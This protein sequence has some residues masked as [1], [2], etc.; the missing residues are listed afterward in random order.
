MGLFAKNPNEVEY[1]GGKKHWTDVIKNS[2][3][4][5]LLIWRQPEEDF[6]TNSTLIVM[7]GEQAIFIK[8]GTIEQVF[9]TSGT[10]KLSTENYPF[11]SRLRNAFSGGISTFN[12]VVYFVR[13]AHSM[14]IKWGTMKKFGVRDKVYGIETNIGAFGSYKVSVS[15]P[16]LFL[17]KLIGNNIV[18]ETQDGLDDYFAD[19]FQSKIV[20]TLS[21][22]IQ[23]FPGEI[24]GLEVEME[25]LGKAIQPKINDSLLDY[26]LK[27]EKFS[28]AGFDIDNDY[29][30][31][32]ETARASA[33]ASN[34]DK[35]ATQ[36]MIAAEYAGRGMGL[37]EEAQ[38]LGS[39]FAG[40]KSAEILTNIANNPASGGLA[41]A[42]Q[43]VGMGMLAGSMVGT[44]V[45]NM[46]MTGM[47][48]GYNPAMG[49]GIQQPGMQQSSMQQMNLDPNARFQQ[50]GMQPQQDSGL[51]ELD[52]EMKR[53]QEALQKGYI[54]QE[55]YDTRRRQLFN[56]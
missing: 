15:N 17:T 31:T 42:A 50:Q 2:G 55:E 20:S 43:G 47:Q 35:I 40:I 36:N 3:P 39:D 14:E 52:L 5:S 22:E 27:C 12:C 7:P 10:Y 1:V 56:L 51:T 13:T 38:Y 9:E 41:N 25:E 45:G 4:G 19:E 26:G 6:N 34:F 21:K 37:A 46:S 49:M 30:R 29:R 11:I 54:S 16:S 8:G 18:F 44:L 28:I 23:A 24:L 33:V 48:Q 53:L 32:I